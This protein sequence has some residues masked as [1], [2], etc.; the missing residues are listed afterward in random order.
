KYTHLAQVRQQLKPGKTAKTG[1]KNI[2]YLF[3]KKTKFTITRINKQRDNRTIRTGDYFACT[4][5]D[6]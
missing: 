3:L 1:L 2:K 5:L 6:F 4:H